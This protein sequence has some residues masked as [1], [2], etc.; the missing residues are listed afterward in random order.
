V[1]QN[2]GRWAVGEPVLI[3]VSG[4]GDKDVAQLS[5]MGAIDQ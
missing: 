4:R 3:C 1:E 5:Q 2:A